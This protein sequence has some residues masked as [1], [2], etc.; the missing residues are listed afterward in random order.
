MKSWRRCRGG[1][2][3]ELALL[4]TKTVGIR[5]G[6]NLADVWSHSAEMSLLVG[7][8]KWIVIARHA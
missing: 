3:S 1:L 5:F 4:K 6:Q 2:K 8:P 7:E